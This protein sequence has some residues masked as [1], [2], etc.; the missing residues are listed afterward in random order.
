MHQSNVPDQL[1]KIVLSGIVDVQVGKATAKIQ[2]EGD[3][4]T[5][6]LN[7]FFNWIPLLRSPALKTLSQLKR[8]PSL[9]ENLGITININH[10]QTPIV[11]MGSR[12]NAD[13]QNSKIIG[14][15]IAINNSIW[16]LRTVS[17]LFKGRI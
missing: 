6:E 2:A 10:G 11:S 13:N 16:W 5:V 4:I 15:N 12:V 14:P 8:L 7:S 9:L 3:V 1:P 17:N